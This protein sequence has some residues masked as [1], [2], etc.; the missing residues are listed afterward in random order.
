VL[1]CEF[2]I[3][4]GHDAIRKSAQR[5]RLQLPG[6]RFEYRLLHVEGEYAFLKW[7]ANSD[8]ARIED[9]PIRSS[10]GAA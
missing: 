4:H 7:R 8:G 9:G 2:G 3:L 10:Y 1:F 6:R 5:A